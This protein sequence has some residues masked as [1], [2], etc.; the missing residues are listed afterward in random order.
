MNKKHK[1]FIMSGGNPPAELNLRITRPPEKK[2]Q[3]NAC[4]RLGNK[5]LEDY[6]TLVEKIF[7]A[8][9][10]K[11]D[12]VDPKESARAIF[13]SLPARVAI[14]TIN[15]RDRD[16]EIVDAIRNE[17]NVLS[18][19]DFT[20]VV[21]Y[22][23][24]F[25]NSNGLVHIIMDYVEGKTIG[26]VIKENTITKENKFKILNNL[27]IAIN[28]LHK[29]NITHRDLK[30]DNIFVKPD[31][32]IVIIDFG[33]SCQLDKK[34]GVCEGNAGTTKYLDPYVKER[35]GI[36]P[37]L[38]LA[39]WW[40]FSVIVLNL[41]FRLHIYVRGTYVE[42]ATLMVNIAESY[43]YKDVNI[44]KLVICVVNVLNPLLKQT[45]RTCPTH[46]LRICNEI[47]T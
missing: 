30:P 18:T 45:E 27:A 34:E 32:S 17:I 36:T 25:E 29:L 15:I 23:G 14:K 5:K 39:D 46:I 37:C 41:M 6:F 31:Y 2:Y 4:V 33:I 44:N 8:G 35:L 21:K 3:I 10:T 38:K 22:Y 12:V 16:S 43:D 7:E 11:I 13:G 42:P 20:F 24:C 9:H 1:Q 28:E 40:S 26:N 47:C 19:L